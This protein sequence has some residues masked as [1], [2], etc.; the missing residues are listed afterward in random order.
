MTTAN[1]THHRPIDAC[2]QEDEIQA[3][4]TDLPGEALVW[5]PFEGEAWGDPCNS[6]GEIIAHAISSIVSPPPHAGSRSAA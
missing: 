1:P 6:L 2:W 5:K 3:L 4:L